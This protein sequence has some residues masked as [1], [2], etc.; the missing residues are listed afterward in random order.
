MASVHLQ[1]SSKAAWAFCGR[2]P[3]AAEKSLGAMILPTIDGV[4][5]LHQIVGNISTRRRI[6]KKSV[7]F[8]ERREETSARTEGQI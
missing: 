5:P 2:S 6:T 4:P 8:R 7:D 3:A 1:A